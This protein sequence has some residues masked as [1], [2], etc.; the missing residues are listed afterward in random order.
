M[1]RTFFVTGANKGIGLA[2]CTALLEQDHNVIATAR[3]PDSAPELHKLHV[4]YGE[5]LSI[6]TLDVASDSS[7]EALAKKLTEEKRSIDV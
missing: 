7:V 5:H 3:N 1:K 4:K 6:E 2:T